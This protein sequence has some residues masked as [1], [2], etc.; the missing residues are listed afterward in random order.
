MPTTAPIPADTYDWDRIDAGHRAVDALNNI[1]GELRGLLSNDPDAL[2][3]LQASLGVILG[4]D[5]PATSGAPIVI[6]QDHRRTLTVE[7]VGDS[8]AVIDRWSDET[9]EP[10]PLR[11]SIRSASEL[12]GALF[13]TTHMVRTAPPTD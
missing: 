1:I 12:A 11:L 13:I 4:P 5:Q 9:G 6:R 8:I 3:Q 10:H 2:L 7:L